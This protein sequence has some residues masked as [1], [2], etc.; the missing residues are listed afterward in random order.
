LHR[1]NL[2]N[3]AILPLTVANEADYDKIEPGDTLV[4]ENIRHILR[5]GGD[6]FA[7]KI[8]SKDVEIAGKLKASP[9][10]REI[11]LVGGFSN[12]VNAKNQGTLKEK[13]AA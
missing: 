5:D 1:Q 4:V 8:K 6:T 7:V 12:W 13:F 9:R 3:S 11:M 10:Q 2:I